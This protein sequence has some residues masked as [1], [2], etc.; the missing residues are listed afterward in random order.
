MAHSGSTLLSRALDRPG[1]NLVIREPV[2][3][4]V[5]GLEAG[6][7]LNGTSPSEHWS[8]L[9]NLAIKM[10]DRR[11]ANDEAL[12]VK[13]NVPVNGIIPDLLAKSPQPR[14]LLLHFGL[15]DYLIAI[16]RS[17][18]HRKWVDHIF[19]ELRLGEH[20]ETAPF[21]ELQNAEK[22]AALWLFQIRKYADVLATSPS[23]RSLDANILFDDPLL[24]LKAASDYFD[25]PVRDDEA[26][27]I[28][29]GS[30]F[31][32]YSKNPN[33][34]FDNTHRKARATDTRLML[35]EEIKLARRYVEARL[36]ISPLPKRLAHPLCGVN[37]KLF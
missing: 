6:A 16:L 20:S 13:A 30:K 9:L 7:L 17:A 27:A 4:R 26:R 11:Y 25:C 34:V 18:N 32:T 35:A 3:L 28:V 19:S 5:L 24:C 22:A 15:D 37:S 8:S 29:S 33:A 31:S 2:T 21:G 23:V 36:A 14:A 12:I 1:N 10:L